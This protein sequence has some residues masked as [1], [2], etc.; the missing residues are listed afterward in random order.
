[1]RAH[2]TCHRLVSEGR[3]RA[4]ELW[5]NRC[6]QGFDLDGTE[7]SF[8]RLDVDR[9]VLIG[10]EVSWVGRSNE[11]TN[12]LTGVAQSGKRRCYATEDKNSDKQGSGKQNSGGEKLLMEERNG[13]VR[14]MSGWNNRMLEL[15]KMTDGTKRELLSCGLHQQ[16]RLLHDASRGGVAFTCSTGASQPPTSGCRRG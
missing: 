1:M 8:G 13:S 11:L 10:G 14:L 3:R 12:E 5:G 15:G 7:S 6:G 16:L 9:F 4:G 2:A